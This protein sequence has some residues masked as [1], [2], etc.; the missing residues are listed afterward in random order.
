MGAAKPIPLPLRHNSVSFRASPMQIVNVLLTLLFF[1]ELGQPLCAQDLNTKANEE[2]CRGFVQ[3]FYDWYAP[4]PDQQRSGTSVAPWLN[5]KVFKVLD[6]Y[7]ARQLR[8]VVDAQE[9]SGKPLLDFDPI[10]N[11]QY[12]RDKYLAGNVSRKG[13]HYLVELY[14][15]SNGRQNGQPDVVPELVFQVGRWIFVNFHYPNRTTPR[16]DENLLSML[17]RIRKSIPREPR[18]D[19]LGTTQDND[20]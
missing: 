17:K 4:N 2:S 9:K 1:V 20:Q 10:L 6:G 7:L 11:S 5:G 13:E 12:A 14:G 8:E 16:S 18:T 15:I 19:S 3:S